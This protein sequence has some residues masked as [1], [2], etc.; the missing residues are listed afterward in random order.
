MV[1]ATLSHQE[2]VAPYWL[3]QDNNSAVTVTV[4]RIE[5]IHVLEKFWHALKGKR[6]CMGRLRRPQDGATPQTTISVIEDVSCFSCF[7]E[8]WSQTPCYLWWYL[9]HK[10][11]YA[12]QFTIV[13]ELTT[14]IPDEIQWLSS[15]GCHQFS[16]A[17]QIVQ[18]IELPEESSI[19]SKII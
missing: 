3:E 4:S 18:T 11:L 1:W 7:P 14:T 5:Y 12:H 19:F 8:S 10:K 17:F 9:K 2:T 13:T 16:R 6:V 15:E